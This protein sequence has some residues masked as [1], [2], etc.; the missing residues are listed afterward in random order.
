VRSIVFTRLD[1][2]KNGMIFEGVTILYPKDGFFNAKKITG[3]IEILHA[4]TYKEITLIILLL[5]A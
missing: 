1:H 3:L 2:R 5:I 4:Y